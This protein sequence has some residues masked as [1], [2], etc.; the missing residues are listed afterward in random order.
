RVVIRGG[1]YNVGGKYGLQ[2]VNL[3]AVYDP[4]KTTWTSV[5]HPEGWRWIGDSPSSVLAD[6]RLLLGDKLT[7]Q[8]A[9]LNPRTLRW[10]RVSHAGKTDY[11]AEEG[12]TLLA[13]G[14]V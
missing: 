2:L 11:N 5:G 3:G 13:D 12:W 8:D 1:E 7:R 4:V 6:G 10:T 14:T 9:Y